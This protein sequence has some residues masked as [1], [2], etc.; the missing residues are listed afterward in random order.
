MIPYEEIRKNEDRSWTFRLLDT[1]RN[2]RPGDELDEVC[3]TLGGLDDPRS[4]E[5][6]IQM[7]E[8]VSLPMHLR[9]AVSLVL[10]HNCIGRCESDRRSWWNSGDRL[11]KLHALLEARTSEA[12][13]L[14]PVAS[15]PEHELHYEAICGMEYGF[16]EPEHLRLLIRALGHPDAAVRQA[17]ANNLTWEEPIEAEDGLI[18]A[19]SDSEHDVADA[20]LTTLSY[21]RS[22]KVFRSL[23]ELRHISAESLRGEIGATFE[24][25]KEDFE[26]AYQRLEGQSKDFFLTWLKPIEDLLVFKDYVKEDEKVDAEEATPKHPPRRKE[27]AVL[28]T[29]KEVIAFFD[30]P[31]GCWS[32]KH[33]WRIECDWN[34]FSNSDRQILAE[35]FR[36]HSDHHI[37]EFGCKPLGLWDRGDVLESF[38]KDACG[39]VKRTAAY[40]LKS[41]TPD[42]AIASSLWKLYQDVNS[43]GN[44]AKDSLR[45]FVV[46]APREGLEDLLTEIVRRERRQPRK[47]AAVDELIKLEAHAH[48]RSLLHLLG[49]PPLLN[50][51]LH[52]DLVDYC[53]SQKLSV[54]YFSE[55]CGVDDMRLQ[56]SLAEAVPFL[57]P[58]LLKGLSYATKN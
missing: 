31:D 35:Y 57:E 32:E 33:C 41:V 2:S 1:I 36:T 26:M 42:A 44:L 21:F 58:V 18:K 25:Q 5:P 27:K 4:I 7:L 43:T 13:I 16:E 11:L 34:Q 19:I 8:D 14:I 48:M 53:V 38:L 54:P 55:L 49:E 51:W 52:L 47:Q 24:N 20:A 9:Q 46:H 12:D 6:L 28:Q 10:R 39:G 3:N 30:D 29:A 37:K 45:S 23:S 22:Q 15:N 50:W 40:C 56:E 17:A